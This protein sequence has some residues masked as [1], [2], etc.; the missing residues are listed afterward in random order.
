L[1]FL[2]YRST[3]L[4]MA[5]P[6]ATCAATS[7]SS[8]GVATCTLSSLGIDNW[9]VVVQQPT[10]AYFT[11][12]NSDPIVLTVYQPATDQFTTGGGWVTDP[13]ANVST[14][15]KHG[16]FGMTVRYKSGTTP[17]GQSVYV[18]RGSDGYDYVIKS[19]SWT[20]GGLSFGA[21]IG[22]PYT[23]SYSGKC[24]VTAIDPKTGLAVTGIGGG[25]YTYRVD[26]ADT[27]TAG[28]DTYAISVYTPTGTL[29]HQAGTT[30]SQL[31]LGGG[32]IVIHNK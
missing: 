31:P 19:N 17:S 16:N 2:L 13:S 24:N 1:S 8:A 15:N 32:N 21:N 9:T 10:N 3:N 29:Y 23:S 7:V 20:G 26:V 14:S 12:Q 25:N 11:A 30:G 27:G 5:T 18:F 6:D 28:S 22:Y 4:M